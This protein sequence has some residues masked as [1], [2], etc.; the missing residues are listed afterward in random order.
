MN[1]SKTS[2]I[3]V[4]FFTV[5]AVTVGMCLYLLFVQNYALRQLD[6]SIKIAE[7][8][9]SRFVYGIVDSTDVPNRIIT[10]HYRHPFTG[11]LLTAQVK[12]ADGAYIAYEEL[13]P[14]GA[15]IFTS[16]STPKEATLVDIT[17]GTRIAIKT[18]IRASGGF[19]SSLILYGNP[20]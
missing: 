9:S 13:E 16:L 4:V 19:E 1:D 15:A 7:I 10:I 12:I 6:K 20:L 8:A 5:F 14:V 18:D 17:P 2:I 11:E 3:R